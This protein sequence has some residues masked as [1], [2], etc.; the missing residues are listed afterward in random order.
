V[1]TSHTQQEWQNNIG[2]KLRKHRKALHLSLTDLSRLSGVAVPALSHIENGNR[3]VKL[4][5]LV[6]LSEALRI[7]LSVLFST[8]IKTPS[9][10]PKPQIKP[11][12]G[13]DLGDD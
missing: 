5:T 4:S 12:G 3:D 13:Y 10:V 7:D 11:I 9:I 1:S 6:R 2:Q 8:N